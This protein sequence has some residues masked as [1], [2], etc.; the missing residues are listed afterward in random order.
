MGIIRCSGCPTSRNDRTSSRTLSRTS[1]A[2]SN[3]QSVVAQWVRN[4]PPRLCN[5]PFNCPIGKSIMAQWS[6]C[7]ST[8]ISRFRHELT[9]L[10]LELARKSAGFRGSLPESMVT[11][12]RPGPVDE[13]HIERALLNDYSTD[14]HKRDPQIEAKAYI[15]FKYNNGSTMADSPAVRRRLPMASARFIGCSAPICHRTCFWRHPRTTARRE[16]R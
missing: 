3:Q 10:A 4:S 7:S 5:R 2:I 13:L 9:D 16:S 6:H 11:A 8:R 12:R 15:Q 14:C 1:T